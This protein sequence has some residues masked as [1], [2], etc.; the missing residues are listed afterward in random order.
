MNNKIQVAFYFRSATGN[1]AD[2][3]KQEK[4]SLREFNR[5][6]FSPT[7]YEIHHYVDPQQAGLS[8]GP[9]LSRLIH[10]LKDRKIQVLIVSRMNRISRS[11]KGLSEFYALVRSV[12]FRFITENENVDSIYWPSNFEVVNEVQ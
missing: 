10:D 11:P 9:S 8:F 2:L 6:G 4:I 3:K 7:E 5:R 12:G 1:L